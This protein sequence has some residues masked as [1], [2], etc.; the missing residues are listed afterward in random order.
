MHQRRAL[1]LKV[2]ATRRPTLC[3]LGILVRR[4]Q[5]KGLVTL[6]AKPLVVCIALA[7]L[8]TLTLTAAVRSPPAERIC[9]ISRNPLSAAMCIGV[10]P[11]F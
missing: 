5:K 2:R 4:K 8:I 7:L 3:K 9:I 11:S 6:P 1:V 10:I